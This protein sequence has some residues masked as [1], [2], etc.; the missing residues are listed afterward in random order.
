[1]KC[2]CCS[3]SVEMPF[4]LFIIEICSFE[5]PIWFMV[6]VLEFAPQ[7]C[8]GD[9]QIQPF[10]LVAPI[11]RLHGH[12]AKT[13]NEQKNLISII[14]AANEDPISHGSVYRLFTIVSL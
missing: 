3:I 12:V 8:C 6:Q 2:K 5:R 4:I 7:F 11:G 14:V 1:M 10:S 9:H 13:L